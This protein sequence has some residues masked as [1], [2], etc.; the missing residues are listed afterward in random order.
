MKILHITNWFPNEINSKEALWVKNQIDS[1]PKDFNNYIIH[2]E[3]KYSKNLKIYRN[4]NN[5][6]FQVI[7]ESPLKSWRFIEYIYFFWLFY[8]IRIKKIHR[9]YDMINFHIAYPMLTYWHKISKQI[10]PKVIITEHWSA[11]HFNF[12]VKKSLPRIQQIFGNKIPVITV[13]KALAN[14][15]KEFSKADFPSYIVP[16]AV[17]RDIFFFNQEKQR[18]N[19]FF[20]IS[21][22]KWPKTPL[23]VIEAFVEFNKKTNR[24]LKLKIGGYGP[25]CK[26]IQCWIKDNKVDNSV[27]LCGKLSEKNIAEYMQGAKAFIHS[28]VYETFSV[29]CA[30][31]ICCGT[32]VVASAVGGIPE[33]INRYNGVLVNENDSWLDSMDLVIKTNYD[34][35]K[36]SEEALERFSNKAIGKSYSQILKKI[37]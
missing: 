8:Q 25:Q 35:T 13:S 33:F 21:Q 5:Q 36:I 20:M 32:P 23:I 24:N 29:V 10:K 31:A 19:Y 6:L 22:W 9:N 27:E 1:L 34:H 37:I 17:N 2:F 12:G 18:E 15:I 11:Y 4:R 26:E 16:N 28:S 14:D 30:E 3:M 7:I